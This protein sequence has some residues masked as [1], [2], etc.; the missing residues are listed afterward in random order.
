MTTDTPANTDTPGGT[1]PAATTDPAAAAAPGATARLAAFTAGLDLAALPG[2]VVHEAKRALV[3]WLAA[4][5]AGAGEPP[6]DALQRASR[7]L[8]PGGTATVVGRAERATAPF[9]ALLSG[10]ASHLQDYDDTF[11]PGDTTVHGSAPVWPVV[12][13]LGE[14]YAVS[15]A[16]ALT[17]FVAGFETEARVGIA[18]GPGHYEAGWHV[19]GTTGHLG[20]AACG[21]RLLGL[22]PGQTA[23]ALGCAGTQAAGLKEVYGTDCKAL[24]PGKAAMDGLLAAVLADEGF[25]SAPTIIEGP[26]GFL[27]VLAPAPTTAPL[28]EG[29][30]S[31]WHLKANG[32]KAYPSGSLTHPT[33]D[34]LLALRERHGFTADEVAS[35]RARVHPYAATVTGKVRPRTGLDAKFSLTHGAA[36]ALTAPRPA[37][38]HFTDEGA[39]DPRTA[40]VAERVEVVAD[41]NIGKRGAEVSVTL[42]SG[43]VLSGTVT[44]NKGTPGNPMTDADLAAKFLDVAAPRLGAGPARSLLDTCWAA[45][46]LADFGDLVRRT[47]GGAA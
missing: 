15:G 25:T 6:T 30:G 31:R 45:E 34:A 24:H 32:Y 4:A 8:A 18:A 17:A 23:H 21:A 40:Q 19:T 42:R 35:V 43:R 36:V 22:T 46:D 2:A 12:F 20:A 38:E 5:L 41:E 47:A 26:R 7:R 33:L 28:T 37:L 27:A 13:A 3:D 14:Q 9:A 39:A 44:D 16:A 1:D 11:N 29:L 10:F